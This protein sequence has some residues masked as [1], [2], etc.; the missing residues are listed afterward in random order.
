ML[1]RLLEPI[2]ADCFRARI[3]I[4]GNFGAANPPAAA[5]LVARLALRLGLPE[6]KIAVVSG[7]DV[8]IGVL[9]TPGPAAQDLCDRLVAVGITSVLNFAPVVLAVP[10]SVDVR[11]VDLSTELQ[12]LAFHEQRKA[13]RVAVHAAGLAAADEDA[14]PARTRVAR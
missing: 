12:I 13:A 5:R 10:D 2:L 11:K 4:L 1:E 7:D 6:L 9:A 3:P 14:A 8:S